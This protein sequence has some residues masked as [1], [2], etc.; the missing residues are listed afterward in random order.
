MLLW[1]IVCCVLFV[2]EFDRG[3]LFMVFCLLW[4]FVVEFWFVS[5]CLWCSDCGISLLLWNCVA[6]FW[7]WGFVCDVLF[8][9]RNCVAEFWLWGFVCG[10]FFLVW[11][12]LVEYCLWF[13]FAEVCFRCEIVLCTLGC[14]NLFVVEV[15]F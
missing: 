14:G 6:Q 13:L 4:N 10:V 8:L 2:V 5:F 12:Y 9:L 1:S 7:V 15:C 11:N 3:V